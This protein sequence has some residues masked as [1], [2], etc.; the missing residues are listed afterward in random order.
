MKIEVFGNQP[1]QTCPVPSSPSVPFGQPGF[2]WPGTLSKL[3]KVEDWGRKGLGGAR[4]S[5]CSLP[6]I[7]G[8]QGPP[9]GTPAEGRAGFA[10]AALCP[11]PCGHRAGLYFPASQGVEHVR[12]SSVQREQTWGL[13]GLGPKH[14]S[15]SS[16]QLLAGHR[17]S[18]RWLGGPR[19]MSWKEPEPRKHCVAQSPH[20]LPPDT[21]VQALRCWPWCVS[22]A[23]ITLTATQPPLPS[24]GIGS[25]LLPSK[26][27]FNSGA[28]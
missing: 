6:H 26:N 7:M 20:L 21:W 10:L 23:S 22:T 5:R 28:F 24:Q 11:F 12:N 16:P 2:P 9:A 18:S 1:S 19:A 17:G 4:N 15:A 14:H 3:F 25:S 8:V 27:S 13:P